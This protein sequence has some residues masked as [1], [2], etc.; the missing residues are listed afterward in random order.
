MESILM[1]GCLSGICQEWSLPTSPSPQRMMNVGVAAEQPIALLEETSSFFFSGT[2]IPTTVS[3]ITSRAIV[4]CILISP[5]TSSSRRCLGSYGTS[6]K[7][8]PQS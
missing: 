6:F 4:S 1:K 5:F 2:E 3:S 7:K 8:S